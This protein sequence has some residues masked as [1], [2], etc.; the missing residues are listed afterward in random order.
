M[1]NPARAHPD[2]LERRI[3]VLE[4]IGT[5][6]RGGME[7]SIINF[8]KYLPPDEFRVTCICPCESLFTK[9]LREMGVEGVYLTPLDDPL[10]RSIQMAMEVIQLHQVDVIHAHMPKSHVLAGIAGSLLRKPVVATVHGMHV[11]AHELGLT[12][13]MGTH[14]I[15]NCQETYV[16]ALTL[17]VPPAR[18]NLFHNGVDTGVFRTEVSGQKFRNFINPDVQA[19]L[20]GFVGRLEHEKGPDLFLLAAGRIHELQPTTHFAVVGDGSMKQ[21]LKELRKKLGLE[22]HLHFI[23]WSTNPA[24]VYPA[25]DLLAHTSRNDGTSLVLLEAMACSIPVVGMAVGGVRE[26]IENEHTGML[27][28]SGDWVSLGNQVV[29]LLEQPQLLH[30]MGRAARM[31]VEAHFNVEVNTD[32]TANLLRRLVLEGGSMK[33]AGS[34]THTLPDAGSSGLTNVAPS[35]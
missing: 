10:W 26:M 22:D 20:V 19:A 17:G 11:T 25:F 35:G 34:Q 6:T 7:N 30:S 4:I 33:I 27:V 32:K 1:Y 23:D 14:L 5:A 12:L 21:E 18:V 29:K 8:L 15:T 24:E 13:A 2:R 9:A 31:R 16:Q 3:S 28:D